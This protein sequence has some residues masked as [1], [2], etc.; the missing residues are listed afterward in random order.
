MNVL[1][2]ASIIFYAILSIDLLFLV[3]IQTAGTYVFARIISA[4][5]RS[6]RKRSWF[7]RC[8]VAFNLLVLGYFKYRNFFVGAM[9]AISAACRNDRFDGACWDILLYLSTNR[10]SYRSRRRQG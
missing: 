7:G 9:S 1:L 10:L 3:I 2:A 6:K 4:E 5:T 8:G